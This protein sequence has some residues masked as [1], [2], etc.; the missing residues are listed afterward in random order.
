MMWAVRGTDR[1][2]DQ[3]ITIVVEAESQAEAEAMGWKRGLPVVIAEPARSEDIKI[4]KAERRL[5]RYTQEGVCRAFGRPV[6]APQLVALM[7]CGILTAM[8]LSVRMSHL[9]LHF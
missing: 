4:A 8:L 5:W 9:A 1:Q 2:T 3:D 7:A 6:Y